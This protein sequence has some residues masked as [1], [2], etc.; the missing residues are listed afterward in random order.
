M[1]RLIFDLDGTLV[2]SAP[3]L[4]ATANALLTELGR[5]PVPVETVLGFV[6]KGVVHL[7]TR[8][9]DHTGGVPG[10]DPAP[11]VARF[12]AIYMDDPVGGTEPYPGVRTALAALAAEGHGLALCTQKPDAP[13]RAIVEGLGLM[14]PITGFTGGDSA[15]VLKP[16]PRMFRHAADQLAPGPEFMI[17]DSEIDAAT[18]HNAGVPFLLYLKGYLHVPP[19]SVGAAAMFDDYADLPGIV[20]GLL[21]EAG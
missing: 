2:E 5:P 14:P 13:A 19:D 8:I 6:G 11:H 7:V 17:G 9:L 3:T 15:G 10:G 16:D 1:A 21:A 12:N 4:A 18:A 20:A